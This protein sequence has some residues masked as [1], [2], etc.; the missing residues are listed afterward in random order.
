MQGLLPAFLISDV[1]GVAEHLRIFLREHYAELMN[2]PV[3]SIPTMLEAFLAHVIPRIYCPSIYEV[4]YRHAHAFYELRNGL[5]EFCF[6]L[7]FKTAAT[8]NITLCQGE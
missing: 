1:I 8:L 4:G 5:V 7:Y 6:G 3:A 2:M